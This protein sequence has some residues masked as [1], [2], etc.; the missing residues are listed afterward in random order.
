M[1]K[2]I[3]IAGI[4]SA[5]FVGILSANPVVEAVGGWQD[6]FGG[7]DTR[8][9]S[10]E[11]Q[12]AGVNCPTGPDIVLGGTDLFLINLNGCNLHNAAMSGVRLTYAN[13]EGA[14]MSGAD[15]RNSYLFHAKLLGSDLNGAQILGASFEGCIGDPIGIPADGTL[16]D[17]T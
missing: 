1:N 3:A 14:D 17:C 7:L 2:T 11:N 16:P 15:L 9:T 10:L 6:A 12:P 13:L 8:I 5:F 4:I